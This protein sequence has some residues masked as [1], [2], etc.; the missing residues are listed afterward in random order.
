MTTQRIIHLDEHVGRVIQGLFPTDDE[1]YLLCLTSQ[2]LSMIRQ[3]CFPY[4][5]W[6]TRFVNPVTDEAF[7][8][9]DAATWSAFHEQVEGLEDAL[10]GCAMPCSD[11]LTGLQAVA[12]AIAG[13]PGCSNT[14]TC[15]TCGG[16]GGILAPIAGLPDEDVLPQ[17]LIVQPPLEG[18]PPD[19]FDSWEE[20]FDRKC[21]ASH[22]MFGW[23]RGLL[24]TL[25]GNA[26]VAPTIA[27]AVSMATV[28]AGIV[29]VFFPPAV[30]VVMAVAIMALLVLASG[31]LID[32]EQAVEYLDSNKDTIICSFYIS[33]SA[34]EVQTI[35]A[36]VIED[37][38]QAVEWGGV[39][40]ILGPEICI[41]VGAIAS[42]FLNNNVVNTMFY[43]AEDLT[44][45]DADCSGCEQPGTEWHFD[46]GAEGW[47]YSELFGE[48]VTASH[49]WLAEPGTPD[50]G[51][52]SH[53]ALEIKVDLPDSGGYSFS[54]AMWSYV[55]FSGFRPVVHAG[56]IF[57]ADVKKSSAVGSVRTYLHITFEDDSDQY[58]YSDTPNWQGVN[59]VVSG[60][61]T[62]KAIKALI[63]VAYADS[64]DR[65]EGTWWFDNAHLVIA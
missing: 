9:A 49:T 64:Q 11:I 7:E 21:K 32:L 50:P 65:T 19:G 62:G 20:Y 34:L 28:I 47:A 48:G 38:V 39:F 40:S 45:P 57:G 63:M 24:V 61:N 46:L 36:S 23:I 37:A 44:F 16:A 1:A 53:G 15:G 5:H 26:N 6:Q 12:A 60:G 18:P 43:T 27:I 41:A 59:V 55:F 2:E 17:P 14:L 42:Q 4:L 30:L 31:A 22:A 25:E 29:G 8:V 54:Y 58:A 10:G 52:S 56:D 13:M 3:M 35:A 33:G 51:D